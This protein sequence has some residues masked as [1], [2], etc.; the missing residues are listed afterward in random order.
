MEKLKDFD[1]T[2][3]DK[4]T[5]VVVFRVPFSLFM[6]SENGVRQINDYCNNIGS[7]LNEVGIKALFIDD[8][9]KVEPLTDELLL[10]GKLKSL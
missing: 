1:V 10:S 3:I 5:K 6:E 7:K 4:D 2:Q 9:T 8:S